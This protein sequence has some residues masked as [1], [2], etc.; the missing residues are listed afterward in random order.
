[1][2]ISK[3]REWDGTLLTCVLSLPIQPKHSNLTFTAQPASV[4]VVS[5]FLF[6]CL[7]TFKWASEISLLLLGFLFY[8]VPIEFHFWLS[9]AYLLW[10]WHF[11]LDHLYGCWLFCPAIL[12]HLAANHSSVWLSR[13]LSSPCLPVSLSG[14]L[15]LQDSE[16]TLSS[17]LLSV[18]PSALSSHCPSF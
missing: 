4:Y 6:S 17:A 10:I 12:C 13:L 16:D 11:F 2:K 9:F 14:C 8:P 3:R 18:L 1:M 5:H 7:I 15:T